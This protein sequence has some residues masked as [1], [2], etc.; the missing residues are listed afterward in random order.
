[1][2]INTT[3]GKRLYNSVDK[4]VV[5]AHAE[6]V[7]R[8][9]HAGAAVAGREAARASLAGPQD[10]LQPHGGDGQPPRRR[11]R[12]P[13]AR[14]QFERFVAPRPPPSQPPAVSSSRSQSD[15]PAA[16]RARRVAATGG[17]ASAAA[18]RAAAVRAAAVRAA[19]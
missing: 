3:N 17:Q 9:G 16:F 6:V 8:P 4:D 14:L 13:S 19:A 1:M 5:P 11:Q 15:G 12:S 18:V 2:L 10:A 7:D